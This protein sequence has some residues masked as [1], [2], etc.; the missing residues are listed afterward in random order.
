MRHAPAETAEGM[1]LKPWQKPLGPVVL[2]GTY[3]VEIKASDTTASQQV[4][5]VKDPRV[6]VSDADLKAQF[7]MLLQIRDRLA[8]TTKAIG[9][10]RAMR[11]QLESWEKRTKDSEQG[12]QIAVAGKAARD[13]LTAIETE[14]IDT[15]TKSSLMAP[16][17]IFEKL[18]ALTEFV[19]SA[20]A[21]PAKQSVEVF[22]KLSGDLDAQLA[23]IDAVIANQISAFN[24]LIREAELQPVG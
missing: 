20:D 14:L 8:D 6:D 19:D 17:R 16:S 4:E 18:N 12:E 11:S 23:R 2:P 24:T 21:A 13:E 5:V 22:E 3:T 9:R 7:D 1:N 15:T 10:V